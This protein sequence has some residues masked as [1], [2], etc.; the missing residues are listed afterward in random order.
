LPSVRGDLLA[1]LA[2]S[3]RRAQSLSVLHHSRKTHLSANYCLNA[4]PQ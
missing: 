2:A 3:M 1:K 4:P